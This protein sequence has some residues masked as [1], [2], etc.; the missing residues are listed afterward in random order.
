MVVGENIFDVFLA[1]PTVVGENI[2]DFFSCPQSGRGKYFG[3]V[4]CQ[5][6]EE[7]TFF[8][9]LQQIAEGFLLQIHLLS[10]LYGSWS[11]KYDL[12]PHH[13]P[14]TTHPSLPNQP[15]H[16]P[17]PQIQ[18]N[19]FSKNPYKRPRICITSLINRFISWDVFKDSS[20]SG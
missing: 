10:G 17:T 14:T 2:L 5:D 20:K 4:F 7:L 16:P 13:L 19:H 6:L 3:R 11:C 15:P 18:T 1:V 9:R 8:G 12:T